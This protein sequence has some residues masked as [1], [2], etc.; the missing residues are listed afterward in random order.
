MRILAIRGENLASLAERFEIDFEAEPLRGAGLFAITGETGAGKSTILDALCLA[1]YDEFPRVAAPGAKED[2]PDA[3]GKNIAAND[4]RSIL[5][6]GAA[7]GFAEADFIARDGLRYRARWELARARGKATGNL[8]NRARGL[9]RI[10][11]EGAILATVEGGV[12]PVNKRIVDLT[13][14]T[15][16]QFRRTVLLAQGDFDA[17]LRA[18]TKERAELLEKITGA[19]IYAEISK[20]AFQCAKE[21][22]Q[23]VDALEQR[24]AD[25]GL[26]D[27]EARGALHAERAHGAARRAE[28]LRE[29]EAVVAERNRH[30]AIARAEAKCAEAVAIREAALR[31]REGVEPLRERLAALARAEPLRAPLEEARRAE[32]ALAQALREETEARDALQAARENL[33]EA[34]ARE[35][36]A[37]A[38]FAQAEAAIAFCEP[39]WLRAEIL[40]SRVD[41]LAKDAANAQTQADAAGKAARDRCEEHA[42]AAASLERTRAALRDARAALERAAAAKPLAERWSEIADWLEKRDDFTKRTRAARARLDELAQ[43]LARGAKQIAAFD[44]ADDEDRAECGRHAALIDTRAKALAAIDENAARARAAALESRA[45]LL[46][47]L[48][49]AARL[50]SDATATRERADMDFDA[51][52]RAATAEE[53]TIA[54]L[55]AARAQDEARREETER[56]GDL[57]DAAASEHAPRLRAALVEGEPCPVCGAREHPH[58]HGQGASRD[59]VTSLRARRDELRRELSQADVSIAQASAREAAAKARRDEA[60]GRRDAAAAVLDRARQDYARHL[61]LWPQGEGDTPP[62]AIE[63]AAPALDQSGA[64]IAAER[65]DDCRKTRRRAQ[66]ARGNRPSAQEP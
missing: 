53:A 55:L 28:L 64:A 40:D 3:S 21:A 17:F 32:A 15:F 1:L 29:R 60:S 22:A 14:L 8:Q 9:F 5:R 44:A 62:A 59:F 46:R 58:G 31:A 20:R 65:D 24:R 54:S 25:I 43:E 42:R 6:R 52:A 18:D 66:A 12:E 10:D 39:Q 50:H 61:A 45:V 48:A 26:L 37:D 16:D 7:R 63:T 27:E 13:S 30:E 34:Q 11:A 19:S 38:I 36:A 23:A 49:M 47:D 57:A 33:G 56:L 41:A 35:S 2:I 51:A 4:P